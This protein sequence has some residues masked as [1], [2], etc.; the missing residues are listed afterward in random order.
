MAFF[1]MLQCN[2]LRRSKSSSDGRFVPD[3]RA[4]SEQL[5]LV[6]SLDMGAPERL[7]S[8]YNIDFPSV[9]CRERGEGCKHDTV[10]G[11]RDPIVAPKNAETR[12]RKKCVGLAVRV[13]TPLGKGPPQN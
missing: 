3:R 12:H 11:M 13:G 8:E 7:R 4:P 5:Q 6:V 9:A 10:G 1:H 2:A